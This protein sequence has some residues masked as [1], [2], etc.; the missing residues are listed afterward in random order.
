MYNLTKKE[1][2]NL[3]LEKVKEFEISAYEIAKSTK[4]TEAG[5]KRIINGTSKNPHENTLNAILE[6]LE[7]YLTGRNIG[8][9][10]QIVSEPKAI[11]DTKE[12]Q[13]NLIECLQETK[14]AMN[15]IRKLQNLL[16]K[17]NIEFE[18]YFENL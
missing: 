14:I 17:N 18:D 12:I 4:L 5:V 15:E 11:Y 3:V 16:R 13:N 6:F 8:K 7:K 2:A 9:E 10:I 1:K